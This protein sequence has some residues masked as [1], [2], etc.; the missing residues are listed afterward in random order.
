[1]PL[2]TKEQFSKYYK[3]TDTCWIWLRYVHSTTGYPLLTWKGKTYRAHRLAYEIY[4]G[5]IPYGLVIDHVKSKGCTRRDCVNPD[6]LEAVT[7]MENI[8]RG[9]NFQKETCV[10]G[11]EMTGYNVFVD[12]KGWRRCRECHNER[13]R[14]EV[15]LGPEP[16]SSQAEA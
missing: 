10:N 16:V 14:R 5:P 1:M 7:Q 15:Y 13:M 9:G 12:R 8:H 6:H 2:P 4:K 3:E 11:H